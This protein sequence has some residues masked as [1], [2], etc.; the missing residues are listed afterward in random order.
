MRSEARAARAKEIEAAAYRV[1]DA[2]GYEGL[3][4]QA[5]AKDAKASNETLYRWYGDKTGLFEAL[6]AGN[7]ALV[8]AALEEAQ[9]GAPLEVLARVGPVLLNML[10]G[11][12]A[13]ALNRAAA[14]D[15][16]GTLGRALGKAGRE[17]VAPWI[18][19]VMQRARDEGI[20]RGE[21]MEMA[22]AWFAL[23]IGD[24]QVRR[25]TGAMAPPD[26]EV[27]AERAAQALARL[28]RLFPPD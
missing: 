26:A 3:S 27:V 8:R 14:A 11:P 7:T 10:L 18:A 22:E 19:G 16:S 4:M 17:T 9:E 25:V 24:L 15:A 28:Q 21:P 20:L 1:L 13:V 2:K 23:L 12:R 5:V 6:I